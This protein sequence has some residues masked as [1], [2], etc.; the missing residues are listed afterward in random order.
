MFSL[1]E[2][3]NE[4]QT[5]VTEVILLGFQSC[6]EVRIFLSILFFLIYSL[7]L[8]GNLLIITLVYFSRKL[9]TPMYFFLTQLSLSDLMLTTDISPNLLHIMLREQGTML[10]AH[11]LFQYYVFIVAEYVECLLL[12]V[13]S[14]DRYLAICDP[15]HY[16]TIMSKMF[17]KKLA[18]ASWL[19]SI[20]TMMISVFTVACL[21]FC[22][23]NIIDH[24]F[25]DILPL[26]KLSC[27]DTF[28]IRVEMMLLSVPTLFIP[29]LLIIISYSYVIFTIRKISSTTGKRKAFSTC[30]AHLTVVSMYYVFMIL[31]YDLPSTGQ[32]LTIMKALSLFYTVG[33]PLLNPIIY[34]LRNEDI[35]RALEKILS[36]ITK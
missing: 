10:L 36:Y 24:F 1:K 2:S 5:L 20:F 33:T 27:S 8:C 28:M 6:R 32:A 18:T 19:W 13:M 23:P 30:S 14:Y 15:L 16:T 3:L 4:N 22:G 12:T 25:C 21:D 29:F 17:C 9:H 11:C 34:S 26:V 35:T 31:I 7:T